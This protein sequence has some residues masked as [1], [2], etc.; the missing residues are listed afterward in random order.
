MSPAWS[1]D[2]RYIAFLRGTGESK[3]YYIIPAL[4]GA[5]RKLSDAYG[6]EQRGLMSQAVA[7]SPDGRTLALVDKTAEDQPWCIYLFS[8]ETGERRKFTTPH[9]PTDGDTTVAFSPDGRTLAFVRSHNLVG[10]V[11]A[12]LA[13]GDIYLA[14][15]AG[16]DPVRLTFGE[17]NIGGLAWMPDSA[18]LIFSA[19]RD[20]SARPIFWRIPAAG[21]APAPI[22]GPTEGVFDP[23][24]STQGGRLAFA[25]LSYDFN[26]YRVEVMGQPDGNRKLGTPMTLISSTRTESDP[27]IS[28]DGRRVVFISNR[29]GYSNMWVC[30]SDGKNPAQLT[31]GR[32]VDMPSWS[33]DSRLI[34][35]NSIA[36]GNSDIYAIGA[37][38]GS[39]R[40]LTT[41]PSAETSPSWSPDGSWLYFSSNRTGRAEVW[42]MPAAGGAAVQLTH[43]GGFNP[44][45]AR[46]GRTVYYLHDEKD[47]WLWSV[48]V[49]GNAET[50][51]L[52]NPEQGKWIE[53]TNWAEVGQ[54]IYFLE[55]KRR[56]PYTL[57]FFDFETRRTTVLATF[58]GPNSP[59]LMLGLTIAP[60]ERSIVYAQRDTLALDLMQ[61]EN[62]Q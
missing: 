34:A 46:D 58:G 4:G 18:E 11:D 28:P 15:V 39:V 62:F 8:V 37:D 59:F 54:G 50:R 49:E 57:K 35:F 13:P 25:Q 41:E 40:R 48:S 30:D 32:Y 60:D 47:P 44:V 1:P 5:E 12:Y 22:V 7:W 21:G 27:R 9:A 56:N 43:G 20:N 10:A 36:G 33:P 55:G 6:W 17:T 14:P 61:V 42:K 45:A 31:E 52:E 24:I 26:I 51:V 2:G 53:P 29:S 16:G 38:G 19:E 23:S 3:G